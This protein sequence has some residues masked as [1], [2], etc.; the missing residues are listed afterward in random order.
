MSLAKLF[1]AAN[2]IFDL[3][4]TPQ[5]LTTLAQNNEYFFVWGTIATEI[6]RRSR[7]G[8]TWDMFRKQWWPSLGEVNASAETKADVLRLAYLVYGAARGGGGLLPSAGPVPS[9]SRCAFPLCGRTE[10]LQNDHVW[11]RA[12]GGPDLSWNKQPLCGFHNRMKSA[13]PGFNFCDPK[14]LV[15]AL[16]HVFL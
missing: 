1:E 5:Q 14:F 8:L 11:P 12:L 7:I 10:D 3:Q 4:L 6:A 15:E 2:S 9:I 16:R 13:F